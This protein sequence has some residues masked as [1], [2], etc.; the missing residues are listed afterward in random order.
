MIEIRNFFKRRVYKTLN[1]D[2]LRQIL[3][4]KSNIENGNIYFVSV[5]PKEIQYISLL[6]EAS[7]DLKGRNARYG[8]YGGFWDYLKQPFK[9]YYL[10]PTVG[11]ILKGK[12]LEDTPLIQK[13]EKNAASE[14]EAIHQFQK[15][16]RMILKF[17]NV[18]YK[19]QYELNQLH[20]TRVIG[21]HTVPLH[22]IIVGM[23]RN[24]KLI[25]LVGGR[26]RLAIAQQIGIEEMTA[27]L[28]LVHPKAIDKLP[29]KRRTITGDNE[30]FRPF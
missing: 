14:E 4:R 18:G 27:I 25:R 1:S 6:S 19:S 29:V 8:V 2:L 12:K 21:E 13:I 5:N 28:T 30:D 3:F 26:H 7:A 23:D 16:E 11:A 9:N 24:G 15:L 22:E 17:K 20:R 10:Y